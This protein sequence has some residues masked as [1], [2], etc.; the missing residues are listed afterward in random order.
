M[1]KQEREQSERLFA[2][3]VR[4]R[5][6][7]IIDFQRLLDADATINWLIEE[8]NATRSAEDST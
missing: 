8:V 7:H 3:V 5:A 6:E 1:N 4:L 2:E